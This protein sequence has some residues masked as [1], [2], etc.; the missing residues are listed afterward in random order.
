MNA[1]V[2]VRGS[3][4]H[5]VTH[6]L[7]IADPDGN[8]IELYIDVQPEVWRDDPQAVLAP[9]E[10]RSGCRRSPGVRLP[11]DSSGQADGWFCR[12]DWE[13]AL[14]PRRSRVV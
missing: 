10:R 11:A 8:E 3:A 12:K 2:D 5:G 1:G 4:D 9:I 7:Y 6:S 13:E 14:P